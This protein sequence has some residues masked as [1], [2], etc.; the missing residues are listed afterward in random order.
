VH[1]RSIGIHQVAI[2]VAPQGYSLQQ[3]WLPTIKVIDAVSEQPLCK[4][5]YTKKID[6][7]SKFNMAAAGFLKT[8]KLP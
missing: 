4:N 3:M 2:S 1:Y 7:G 8:N 6:T 5:A